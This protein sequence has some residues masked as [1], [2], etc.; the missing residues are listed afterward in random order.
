[1]DLFVQS[2]FFCQEYLV[3]HLAG[4]VLVLISSLNAF[5][6]SLPFKLRGLCFSL[7]NT[8]SNRIKTIEL[9]TLG[10]ELLNEKHPSLEPIE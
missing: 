5:L 7:M 6:K 4:W 10:E 8:S 3:L 1:M 9:L 2:I